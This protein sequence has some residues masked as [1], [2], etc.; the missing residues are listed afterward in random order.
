MKVPL[1]SGKVV[2]VAGKA[3]IEHIDAAVVQARLSDDGA[4][5]KVGDPIYRGDVV[6]TG[7]DGRLGINF[8]DGSSFSLSSNASMEMNEF[9]YDPD[10]KDNSTLIRLDVLRP[11]RRR[12]T[13]HRH[14]QKG[15]EALQPSFV[16]AC[17]RS[18]QLRAPIHPGANDA[19]AAPGAPYRKM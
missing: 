5:A 14:E 7:A 13:R 11:N 19:R 2:T 16:R 15:P 12:R 6:R 10:G 17:G 4:S 3:M 18:R 1:V 8:A 9:V